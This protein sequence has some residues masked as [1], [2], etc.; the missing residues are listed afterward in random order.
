MATKNKLQQNN[1]GFP[2]PYTTGFPDAIITQRAPTTSDR[3]T[4]G[5]IWIDKLLNDVYII[6]SVS[7]GFSTWMNIAGGIANFDIVSATTGVVTPL[8]SKDTSGLNIVT[9]TAGDITIQS[10]AN[11]VLDA[12]DYFTI[13]ST[14]T[15]SIVVTGAGQDLDLR[16]RGGSVVISSDEVSDNAISLTTEAVAGGI[17]FESG[18]GGIGILSTGGEIELSS[19]TGNVTMHPITDDDASYAVT[20]N[21]RVGVATY[22]GQVLAAAATTVLT[23]TNSVCTDTSAILCTVANKGAN[24][25]QLHVMR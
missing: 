13:D 2:S 23:V 20:I 7:N 19:T 8:L 9:T 12:A 5:T 21:A 18:T 17:S 15:S 3:A 10:A 16:S 24:D 25:A 14:Q 1:Y 6:T 22:T 4:I 11:I